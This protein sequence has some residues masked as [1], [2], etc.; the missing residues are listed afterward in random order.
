MIEGKE[1][2]TEKIKIKTIREIQLFKLK[3]SKQKT[4]TGR[5]SENVR[6]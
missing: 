5:Q 2:K 6:K 3:R 1:K 4:E